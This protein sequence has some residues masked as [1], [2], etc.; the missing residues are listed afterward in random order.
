MNDSTPEWCWSACNHSLFLTRILLVVTSDPHIFFSPTPLPILYLYRWVWVFTRTFSY[1]ISTRIMIGL[2]FQRPGSFITL[3]L[4]SRKS[5]PHQTL[6]LQIWYAHSWFALSRMSINELKVLALGTSPCW[7]ITQSLHHSHP[8][9]IIHKYS[10]QLF[11]LSRQCGQDSSLPLPSPRYLVKEIT[12]EI[13]PCS[14]TP[15]LLLLEMKWL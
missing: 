2:C 7:A 12:L 15:I 14:A 9:F 1:Y 11:S 4:F 6:D 3:L 10:T 13:S 5:K 8:I